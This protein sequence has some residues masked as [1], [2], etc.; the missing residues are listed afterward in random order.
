MPSLRLTDHEAEALTAFLMTHGEKK[1]DAGVETA[2]KDPEN[3]KKGEAL[4]RKYGCFGC[5]E[6]EGMEQGVAHRR[7]ADDRWLQASSTNCFS[8][9]ST[10]IPET[11]NDWTYHKLQ[12]PRIY[13]TKDVEQLMPNFDFDRRRHQ[14]PARVPRQHDRRQGAGALPHA[15]DRSIRRRSSRAGAWSIIYNCVGCHIVENRG[16]YIRRFYPE[17]KSTLRRRYSMARASRYSPSGYSL[18]AGADADS[19]VAEDQDADLPFHQ[20]TKTTRS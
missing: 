7:R 12:T 17:I 15:R 11:W 14:Q 16:G 5:H 19:A 10:D 13:Q 3:I 6:I 1:E 20:R 9:T 4:V 18:P 8:A 2:L